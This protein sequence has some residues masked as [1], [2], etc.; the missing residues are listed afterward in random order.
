MPSSPFPVEPAPPD[1]S[2]PPLIL[3]GAS[4]RAAAWSAIR[5]GWRPLCADLFGDRDLASLTR[6]ITVGDYPRGLPAAVGQLAEGLPGPCPRVYTGALENHPEIIDALAAN[7]PLWGNPSDVLTLIRDP[8]WVARLC[9]AHDLPC[10]TLRPGTD[11]PPRDGNWILRST[12]SGGGSGVVDWSP[13]FSPESLP[14][15]DRGGLVFQQKIHG[16]AAAA[17]CVGDGRSARL[18]GT[19]IQLVG[20]PWLSATRWAW[21]GSI[22]PL[23]LPQP[24]DDRVRRLAEVLVSAAGLRGL[25]GIDMVI[26]DHGAWPVEINPR[27]TASAEVLESASGE[28]MIAEHLAV[29]ST[30]RARSETSRM[31]RSD[32]LA[33]H[34]KAVLFA[35]ADL[36]IRDLPLSSPEPVTAASPWYLADVPHEGTTIPA[37]RPIC[38]VLT[39]AATNDSCRENLQSAA[40][41]V[42]QS[43]ER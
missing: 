12:R 1:P 2:A 40:E 23:A 11:P 13:E 36:E 19:T 17:L 37:G 21:C 26:N 24:I 18:L 3:V 14:D 27:Y 7:G 25:F 28:S 22:G 32:G 4:T 6:V 16:R 38:T 39:S 29:F 9:Q 20:Q 30:T 15:R 31:A 41:A 34:G 33:C 10:P 8:W 35:P 42:Y 43:Q 5:A